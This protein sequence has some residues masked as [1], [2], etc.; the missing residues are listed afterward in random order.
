MKRTFKIFALILALLMIVPVIVACNFNNNAGDETES[1]TVIET[2]EWGQAVVNDGIPEDLDYGGKTVNILIRGGEQYRREWIPDTEKEELDALDQEIVKRNQ[3]VSKRIGVTLNYIPYTKQ[4]HLNEA[5]QA[6]GKNGTGEYDIVSNYAAYATSTNV[7]QYY[8]N[9]NN[10]VFTY[11][12]L[13]KPYWNQNFIKDAEA[14]GK[15]YVCV[16]DANLSVYDRAIVVFFNKAKA[17]IYLSD[18][19]L[20]QMVLEKKWTYNEFYKIICCSFVHSTATKTG[21]NECTKTNLCNKTGTACS[22]LAPE[23]S[24]NALR[25]APAFKLVGNCQIAEGERTA[26]VGTCPLGNKSGACFAKTGNA[27]HTGFGSERHFAGIFVPAVKAV[28]NTP[29]AHCAGVVKFKVFGMTGFFEAVSDGADNF[30]GEAGKT[31]ACN[32]YGCAVGNKSGG[33]F[34]AYKLCHNI[35]PSVFY[36]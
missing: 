7:L 2:D 1:E 21:V 34:C 35:P 28:A 31:H 26:N 22:Y 32:A 20:Y 3:A 29:V 13:T 11:M 12:D 4:E 6:A 27:A 18:I 17:E 36:G 5:I 10:D 9:F 25:E 24:G 19:N 30:L 33:F 14:F 23:A 16:G 8:M 15:L